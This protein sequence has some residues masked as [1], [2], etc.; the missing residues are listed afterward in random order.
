MTNSGEKRAVP[1]IATRLRSTAHSLSSGPGIF[2]WTAIQVQANIVDRQLQIIPHIDLVP[3]KLASWGKAG[4]GMSV[5]K[6]I[7]AGRAKAK[8]RNSKI[9]RI[10]LEGVQGTHLQA[11]AHHQ[12]VYLNVSGRQPSG[13]AGG[14]PVSFLSECVWGVVT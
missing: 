1:M 5:V 9:E 8:E 12:V 4:G 10:I 6:S 7:C 2:G 14:A 11:T 3:K 13:P